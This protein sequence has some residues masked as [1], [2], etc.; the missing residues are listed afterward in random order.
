MTKWKIHQDWEDEDEE[1]NSYTL[2][3]NENY[4]GWNTDSSAHG[5]GLPKKL[6]QWI[7]DKLNSIDDECPYIMTW[8]EWEKKR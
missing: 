1:C 7:C 4:P 2:T 8:G 5:Y 3:L 6:A